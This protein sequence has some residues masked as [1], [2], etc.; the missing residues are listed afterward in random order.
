M[1]KTIRAAFLLA[2]AATSFAAAPLPAL[3]D[4]LEARRDL[5]G[6][7]AMAQPNGASYEFFA[8]LIPPPR[9]VHADFRYYPITLSAPNAKVKARL[10]SNGSGVNFTG[11]SRSWHEVGVPFTFRVGPDEFLFG[12]LHNRLHEPTLAEGYLPIA[13]IRYEHITPV[14]SEGAVPLT[15]ERALRPA[16]IYAVEAFASTEPALAEN[17][18][19]FVKFSLTQGASGTIAV[20]V[21]DKTPLKFADGRL[22]NEKGDVV[23]MVDSHWKWERNRLI[24]RVTQTNLATLAIATKPLAATV[25]G[26]LKVDYAAQRQ[27]CVDTWKK[28]LGQS[29]NVQVPEPIV[30]N[31]WRHLL[32]QNVQLINGDKMFY[33]TGNQYQQ[34]YSAEGSDAALSFMWWGYENDYRRIVVPILDFTRAGLEYH[35]AGF[36][37]NNVVRYY[38]QTRDAETVRKLRPRWEKEVQRLIG[39]RTGP[40]GLFPAERYAGDISTPTQTLNANAKAWRAI[41]D[42]SAMLPE[43]GE[44]AEAQRYAEI[45]GDF[46]KIVLAAIEKSVHRDTTPPFIPNALLS[47]E[48]THDPILHSRIGSYWNITI[49]YTIAAGIFP[50]GSAEENWI[51]HYQEQHGGIFMGMIRSGG[52]EFNFWTGPNRIN[53]LYGTR[54]TLDTLRRDEPERALV[55]FYGMLAQGFT[56]NTFVCGEGC[57]L[58]PVDEGGRFFY[59]PPNS[60][61]NGHFLSML[62]HMLVQDSDLDDD[63]KPE[64]LRLAFAT[65]KRWLEDGKNIKIERAPTA[66]GEVS[67][68]LQSKLSAGEVIADVILPARNQPQRTLLRARVPDGWKITSATD[69]TNSLPVDDKGTVDLSALKGTVKIVFKASRR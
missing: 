46:R 3:K 53:P 37:I 62:R 54:Y 15:Q 60:A 39:N 44:T 42:L 67:F 61:A 50:V 13:E 51:P 22:T 68:N 2:T 8:P 55:S 28:I 19:V 7:A 9:Y 64:T 34:L 20:V 56:R 33:S 38:W 35:Q 27:A 57:T 4:A 12:G 63:G 17:A 24:A 66:F 31:A 36:K 69:G 52:D 41:R 11:G 48:P 18:V 47:D 65:S 10:I 30:N 25:A 14:Q 43:I 6:E 23:A 1:T 59:C 45:A 49:G 26:S 5:Y 29:M 21:E 16:E 40:G 58:L 32:L